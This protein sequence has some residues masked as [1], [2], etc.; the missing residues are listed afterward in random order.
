MFT[1]R[2]LLDPGRARLARSKKARHHALVGL[3][4]LCQ[5]CQ[6]AQRRWGRNDVTIRF[7][8]SVLA[9]VPFIL[10]LIL[11]MKVKLFRNLGLRVRQMAKTRKMKARD[12][13]A[14]IKAS[15]LVT[16]NDPTDFPFKEFLRSSSNRKNQILKDWKERRQKAERDKRAL[17]QEN[18]DE[19]ESGQLRQSGITKR[20][21]KIAKLEKQVQALETKQDEGDELL[22]ANKKKIDQLDAYVRAVARQIEYAE[23]IAADE[24]IGSLI[25]ATIEEVRDEFQVRNSKDIDAI[26][27]DESYDLL[28]DF[29][30]G[31]ITLNE[32][33]Q[34]PAE[35]VTEKKAGY[36]LNDRKTIIAQ[37]LQIDWTAKGKA[38][39]TVAAAKRTLDEDS[40]EDSDEDDFKTLMS[41][42]P[43]KK[44]KTENR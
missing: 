28:N 32:H 36:D 1:G 20:K 18:D 44:R 43:H 25:C 8:L 35:I 27:D 24:D 17:V 10:L 19:Y 31:G 39:V 40:D 11:N 9:L 26:S 2:G 13:I 23:A 33:Y 3:F 14:K 5:F 34:G 15:D 6:H 41:H 30:V 22:I 42:S 37:I 21:N 16:V 4:P 29:V 12:L 7:P 38:G